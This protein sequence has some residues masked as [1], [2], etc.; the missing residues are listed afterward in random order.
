[1][2]LPAILRPFS[3]V[4]KVIAVALAIAAC[5]LVTSSMKA[6]ALTQVVSVPASSDDT[7]IRS[8]NR[9]VNQGSATTITVDGD[10][11]AGTGKSTAALMRFSLPTLPAGATI[12]DTELRLNVTNSSTD[13]YSVFVMK[14]AWVEGEATW[15][16]YETASVWDL[17]G[18]RGATDRE[19][20]ATAS[21]TPSATGVQY[22]DL[23]AAF[24][25][26][27]DDWMSGEEVNNGI[28]LINTDVTDGFDFSTREVT[29]GSQRPQ[30]IVTYVE[31]IVAD[32]TPPE[33]TITSGAAEGE[34]LTVDSAMFGFSSS[35]IGSTFECSLDGDVFA[36]CSS[37]Q[38]YANL[39][40]GSHTFAVRAT[41][42]AANTDVTPASTT[43]SVDTIAP[44]TTIDS[45]PSGTITV[46]DA[47]FAFSSPE[48]GATFECSL[49]GAAYSACTSPQS[50]TSLS[51]GQHT[52]SVRA[53][54]AA[55]NTNATPA[56]RTWTVEAPPPPL[57]TDGDGVIDTEDACST[58][59]G[60][61]SNN[62]CPIP[63]PPPPT[64][65]ELMNGQ[66]LGLFRGAVKLSE[67]PDISEN[68]VDVIREMCGHWRDIEGP[69]GVYTHPQAYDDRVTGLPTGSAAAGP[70]RP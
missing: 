64:G 39:S 31:E 12:T 70:M 1:V 46:A 23:G 63:P 48:A 28:Q 10:E 47:T 35:E 41:D 52:F 60:P 18:G 69:R 62:G 6:S 42:A 24:D 27:V 3:R 2:N 51:V 19:S 29:T 5:V 17:A 68:E 55:G 49:D 66:V 20:A 7:E 40:E 45:G 43:F 9:M 34:P 65:N 56:T 30:L 15:N 58:E 57:D 37:P 11:P 13:T 21:I 53:T 38:S 61:A 8:A 50:F 44:N 33:T 54:D 4:S 14:K 36:S 32:T 26:Q 16:M 22:F 25:Q 67:L 59:A